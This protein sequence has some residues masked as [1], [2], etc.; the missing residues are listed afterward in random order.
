MATIQETDGRFAQLMADRMEEL[1]LEIRDV[2]VA[3]EA[4]YEYVR[5][6]VRGTALPSKRITKD[7]S[8][9]LKVSRDQLETAA[10][11]D[12]LNHKYGGIPAQLAGKNP[13]LEP[14]ER[15]VPYL[16][17]KQLDSLLDMANS[18]KKRNKQS[19]ADSNA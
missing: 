7:L 13:A 15:V 16:T 11:A 5:R 1:G 2:S 3:I 17:S 12:K 6:L 14:F 9:L 8:E 10:V 18:F 4:T 19:K